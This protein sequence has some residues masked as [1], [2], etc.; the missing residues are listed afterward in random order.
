MLVQMEH[1]RTHSA[2]R[3]ALAA[4]TLRLHGWVY[5]FEKGRVDSYDPLTGKFVPLEQQVRQKWLQH[6]AEDQAPRTE[7]DTHI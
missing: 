3:E 6:A 4:R 1:L 7:W 5:H 2:V